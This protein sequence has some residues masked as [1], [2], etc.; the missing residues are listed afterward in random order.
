M[1]DTKTKSRSGLEDR[2]IK[3]INQNTNQLKKVGVEVDY[4]CEKIKYTQVLN[5][6]YNPDF[7]LYTN[8]GE[9]IHFE[10]KGYWRPADRQKHKAIKLCNNDLNIVFIFENPKNKI[11]KKSKTTYADYCDKN[12]Y[13]W[14]SEKEFNILD[15]MS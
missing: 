10:A 8:D 12:G 14:V 15:Y 7:T 1:I 11:S 6:T 13:K 3:H 2:I 4:E 5:R 9:E